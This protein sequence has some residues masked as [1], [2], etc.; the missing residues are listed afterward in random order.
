[1]GCRRTGRT[2]NQRRLIAN[3]MAS[4]VAVLFWVARCKVEDYEACIQRR[5]DLV[6]DELPIH[7]S[8]D[9]AIMVS[10]EERDQA[11]A[12]HTTAFTALRTFSPESIVVY[13]IP[14]QS[15]EG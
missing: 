11:V 15:D 14:D 8:I 2:M 4:L 7:P 13:Y 5:A 9:I 1:M 10:A 6:K 3:H 12:L